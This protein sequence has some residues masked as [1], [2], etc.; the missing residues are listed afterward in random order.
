MDWDIALRF[1]PKDMVSG[2]FYDFYTAPDGSL[3]GLTLMDVSGHGVAS[4]LVTM[5]ARMITQ[6]IFSE[7]AGRPLDEISTMINEQFISDIGD[8]R[9]YITGIMLS[10]SGSTVHYVNA[11]HTELI[12]RGEH[13]TKII[14]P[15]LP[16]PYKALF[17]GIAD[18][19]TPFR[20]MDFSVA[21]GDCLFLFSDCLN[22][23]LSPSGELFGI[24][25]ITRSVQEAPQESAAA[26]MNHVMGAMDAFTDGTPPGDDLTVICLIRKR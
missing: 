15:E 8:L 11:A 21:P 2:D 12:H 16:G 20:R 6:R 18:M 19:R 1:T 14:A 7:H 13:G 22:E 24:E 25:R 17:M 5:I 3:S 10:F 26:V 23:A 4:G 9:H